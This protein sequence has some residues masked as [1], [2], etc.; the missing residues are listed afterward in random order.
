[1]TCRLITRLDSAGVLEEM[2]FSDASNILRKTLR[3]RG[4][5]GEWT[6]RALLDKEK[7]ILRKLDLI[8]QLPP[9]RGPGRPLKSDA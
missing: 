9:K 7:D 5:G 4:R 8:P 3:F 2:T 6:Y 1:M